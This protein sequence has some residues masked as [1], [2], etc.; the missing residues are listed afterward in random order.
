MN[1]YDG[2]KKLIVNKKLVDAITFCQTELTKFPSSP[3]HW[4]L[5]KDMLH[6]STDLFDFIK[7]NFSNGTKLDQT[8][9]FYSELNGFSINCDRWFLDIVAFDKIDDFQS[10][11]SDWLCEGFWGSSNPEYFQITGWEKLQEVFK[12]YHDAKQY[13][14]EQLRLIAELTEFLVILRLQELF[15]QTIFKARQEGLKW[16]SVPWGVTAHD[17]FLIYEIRK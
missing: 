3:F 11:H 14:S 8:E 5:G 17:Y 12:V 4:I 9:A 10:E 6:L 15:E 2:I 1:Y 7:G 16:A 13:K